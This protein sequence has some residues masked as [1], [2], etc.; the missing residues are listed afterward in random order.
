MN[1][2]KQ[3]RRERR[4][5]N[6]KLKPD[7]Y[8]K[9]R[10]ASKVDAVRAGLISPLALRKPAKPLPKERPR[11]ALQTLKENSK[12]IAKAFIEKARVVGLRAGTGEGKTEHAVS[13]AVD[14]RHIAMSLN[15]LPLAEQVHNRF[16]AARD[17]HCSF[18]DLAGS[19]ITNKSSISLIPLRERIRDFERGDVMCVKPHLCEAAQKRGVPAPVAVC[20]E[21]EVRNACREKRYLSQIPKAQQTQV[22]CI[23]Q[24]KLFIDP[25]HRE[26]FRNISQ[27]QPSD[28]V[29]VI[30]EAKA[31]DLFIECELSKAVLQQWVKD[32]S[33][34]SLGI[35]AEKVLDM[36]EVRDVSPFLVAELVNA[37]NDQEL[38]ELSRRCCRYRVPYEKVDR[39]TEVL[40]DKGLSVIA[41]MT[42]ASKKEYLTLTPAQAFSR[43]IYK[44]TDID[45][46]N[47]L[48]RLWEQSTW[49]PFQQLKTF[50]QRYKREDDA[51][52]WYDNGI[53]KWVIPPV[54]HSQVKHLVCMSA[55]LQCEGF[56]R[57][58]D[59]VSSKFRETPPTHW[60][61]GAKA[62]QVRTGRYPRR[63]LIERIKDD[64]GKWVPVNLNTTGAKFLSLIENEVARDK[65]VKHV[66]I[67]FKDIV[68]LCGDSL[69]DKHDNLSVLSF[70]KME[71]LD[72]TD[73]GIV[74]WVLGCPEI[75]KE[76]IARRARVLYGNDSEALNNERDDESRQYIDRRVQLCWEAEVVARLMQ[77]VG[78]ARL[79]RLANTVVVFSNVLIPGFTGRAVGFVPEDME[80]AGG[81]S[82][83]TEVAAARVKVESETEQKTA[84]QKEQEA[85]DLKAEQK[86]TALA[87]RKKGLPINEI[88]KR[89]GRN[90]STVFRWIQQAKN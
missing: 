76:L 20:S 6:D 81:L 80:V 68:D 61:D 57:A 70:H 39:G 66:L 63:S 65:A 1:V 27:G 18:G 4:D 33:G 79:N 45:G 52:I 82:N 55:T 38:R 12:E 60:V 26:F 8:K 62:F 7:D 48:P 11:R 13:L 90:K 47:T 44:P 25:M 78:R 84:R 49:T 67:T 89:I 24:P 22:L 30:D 85:R 3:E 72:F 88:G 31:H 9:S 73:S 36:L 56:E 5:K 14:G 28:R 54:V 71:G 51:P 16:N 17:S 64:S 83:L 69:S 40:Q 43:G 58:F 15:T 75:A 46:I 23:A 35:F 86:Q 21:C 42:E 2:R 34:E 32:W 74:V 87:L 29:C 53:L 50:I 59:S 41:P 19:G 37:Y 77:A 10:H